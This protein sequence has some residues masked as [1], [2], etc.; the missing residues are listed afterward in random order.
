MTRRRF[1]FSFAL[2]T[3]LAV[4]ILVLWARSYRY[5]DEWSMATE[6]GEVRAVLV[7]QGAVHIVRNGLNRAAS[8][9]ISY[10]RH[11]V[12]AGANWDD[13]YGDGETLWN[14]L[15]FRKIDSGTL[16]EQIARVLKR[17]PPGGI[18]SA[19]SA[20]I[21]RTRNPRLVPWIF[22][23]TYTAWTIP[24]WSALLPCAWPA[25]RASVRDLRRWNRRR[26]NRCPACAYDLRATPGK[27]PECGWSDGGRA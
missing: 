1:I 12:P 5:M 18:G 23:G 17:V 21:P 2:P 19:P 20:P 3:A 11:D 24:I 6:T 10:D 25:A 15:G 9:P 27:C 14:W 8:R 13:L 7:Y 16:T 22:A 4:T 26:R